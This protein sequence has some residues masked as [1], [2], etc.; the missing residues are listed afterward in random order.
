MNKKSQF[1]FLAVRSAQL[2]LDA[3]PLSSAPLR[4]IPLRSAQLSS[5]GI[6]LSSARGSS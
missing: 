1:L 2:S 5:E 4:D 6:P 3:I